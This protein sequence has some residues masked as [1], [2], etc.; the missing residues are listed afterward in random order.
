MK[1]YGRIRGS[2]EQA[3]P[4]IIGKDT[5]YVHTDIVDVEDDQCEYNEVQYSKDEYIGLM[6]EKAESEN[7]DVSEMIL[8]IDF[9]VSTIELGL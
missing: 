6:S 1:D 9:R 3:K 8:D 2:K 7:A 5:V 4:L